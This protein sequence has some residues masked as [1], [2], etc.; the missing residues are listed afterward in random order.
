[1]VVIGIIQGVPIQEGNYVY[2][3]D[4]LEQNGY[5][6]ENKTEPDWSDVI[7]QF[8]LWCLANNLKAKEI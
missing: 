2:L 6:I 5:D 3:S 1:M 8:H 7:K 4:W